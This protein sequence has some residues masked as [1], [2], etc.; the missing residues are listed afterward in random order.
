[1][2]DDCM[3]LCY[4]RQTT[5]STQTHQDTV[6]LVVYN[7]AILEGK[8]LCTLAAIQVQALFKLWRLLNFNSLLYLSCE[9]L[10]DGVKSMGDMTSH[11][12]Y[13]RW[14]KHTD[15]QTH[16]RTEYEYYHMTSRN[17]FTNGLVFY[18]V[19]NFSYSEAPIPHSRNKQQQLWY[20]W[21]QG[22]VLQPILLKNVPTVFL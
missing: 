21:C 3:C 6:P 7:W 17:P 20:T 11:S 12:W 16:T 2:S 9:T 4:A 18:W 15:R 13:L 10:Q 22:R 19:I 5:T 1:M 14:D 8:V